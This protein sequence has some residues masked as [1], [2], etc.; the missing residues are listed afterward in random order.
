MLPYRTLALLLS[1]SLTAGCMVGP[2]YK[3]PEVPLADHY[4]TAAQVNAAGGTPSVN[5]D[6]WWESFADPV[7]T[8]LM[9]Q[10]LEQNLGLAQAQARVVQARAVLGSA[11]AALVPSAAIDGQ[12]ARARQS[13]ETPLG[14]VLNSM[15][16]YDRY[17]NSY[18]LEL[19]ASWEVDLF[20]GL[21]RDR[22]AAFGEY[23][24]SAAG[25]VATRLAVAA[26]TADI[27][28]TARGLQARL[29]IA[30]K[31]VQ[32]QQDLLAKVSLL[33]R[34]GVA[35]DFEVRQ[36]E[37]ELAQV[38]ATVPVL[39]AGLEGA[40]NALDVMLGTAPG[41]HRALMATASPIPEVPALAQIGAPADLLRRRPDLIAAER[42]LM[43]TNAMIGSAISE[44]YPKF[45]LGAMIGSASTSAGALFSGDANQSA[46]LLG[47]R[48]RLFDFGRIN[49]QLDQAKGREA[50]ALAFYKQSVLSASQDVE[51]ALSALV[52]RQA[53]A[54]AL[55]SAEVSLERARRSSFVAFENGAASLINV[56]NADQQLL[57]AS[58]SRA[59]AQTEAVRAAIATYRALGG[60][61]SLNSEMAQR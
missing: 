56:L 5:L 51:T 25:A 29:A 53:Q 16:G 42:R 55:K 15:P 45:S 22:E 23:Q 38:E 14:Q 24:A 33:N 52:N 27:Y 50:E 30:Q 26:Q 4:I 10:A 32:T 35:A 6:T 40:L 43:S 58:D 36:T 47:L 57:R 31:Q 41:T 20:G 2:D 11:N 49:A 18:E 17:G 59:V 37:G 9:G 21:R 13:V 61:W 54:R 60:G 48:W 34:K 1:S 28:T 12:A 3:Q 39:R 46:V 7:L 19:G 8:R 44:Y